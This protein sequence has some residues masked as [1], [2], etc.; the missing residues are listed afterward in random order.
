M[1]PKRDI[2][3]RATAFDGAPHWVHPARLLR[4]ESGIVVTA[5]DAGCEV[6]TAR[7]PWASPFH[8]LGHYWPHRHYNVIRLEDEG[9][10]GE[11]RLNGFY[12][13]IATPVRFD[14][15][16]LSYVD[17]QLDVNVSALEGG[18]LRYEVLDEAEFLEARD[19]FAYPD[20][21]VVTCYRAVEELIAL[22]EARRFPFD[23]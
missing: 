20:D 17:L 6:L 4:H 3:V 18:A 21:L 13:N 15:L 10:A 7:G 14:G 5:T 22:I 2:W 19:R 8:T 12:C 16:D 23:A 9:A 11:R 1:P